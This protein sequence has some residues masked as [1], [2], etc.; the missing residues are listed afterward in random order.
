[1]EAM[2]GQKRASGLGLV[3]PERVDESHGDDGEQAMMNR[4]SAIRTL[5]AVAEAAKVQQRND[6][7]DAETDC[8]RL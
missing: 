3:K 5:G 6:G 7:Q 8:Q 1:L 4:N 2:G